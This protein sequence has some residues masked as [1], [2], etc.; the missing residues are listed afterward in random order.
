[1]MSKQIQRQKMIRSLKELT[2][3]KKMHIEKRIIN[4]LLQSEIWKRVTV[5]AITLSTSF[6][7]DTHSIIRHAWKEGKTVLVPR[8]NIT[9]KEL[10]FYKIQSFD[11]L[12]VGYANL[13]E[14]DPQL[15]KRVQ[16]KEIDLIIVPGIVF[17]QKGYR[18]GF[19]GG[20]YDR[21]LEN[22]HNETISLV[23]TMQIIN[24]VPKNTFDIPVNYLIT[25]MNMIKTTRK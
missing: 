1:M 10:I 17:D 5:V 4:N 18:I 15:T 11:Q 2:P 12:V 9:N 19:G 6:E 20:Y 14:P 3:E 24:E 25:E 23:G 21:F 16:K 22:F 8:C 7:W 13:L